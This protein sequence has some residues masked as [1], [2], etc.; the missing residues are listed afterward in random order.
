MTTTNILILAPNNK[1]IG[2]IQSFTMKESKTEDGQTTSVKL[3]ASRIRFDRLKL[4]EIFARG[5]F[6]V[7]SQVYPVHIVTLEDKVETMRITNAWMS[8]ITVSYTTDE[9]IIAEGVELEA[10]SVTQVASQ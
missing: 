5:H 9:W 1:P 8:G 7:A 10:E 6:H 2:A 3:E 4:G